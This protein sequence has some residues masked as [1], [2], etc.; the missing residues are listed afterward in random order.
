MSELANL[1]SAQLAKITK[2]IKDKEA[3]L[4]KRD[5]LQAK[6]D[7]ID[8]EL[9]KS[10]AAAPAK[11][12]GRKPGRKAAAPK[13]KGT[14]KRGAVKDKIV[15][16]LKANPKG[17]TVQDIASKIKLDSRNVHSWFQTTGKKLSG[18]T[19]VGRAMYT[20]KAAK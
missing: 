3:L 14:R 16:L 20:I 19:K 4:T 17:I 11:R 18:I 7:K 6:I 15:A 9:G 12:R 13:A 2:L 5:A 8:A 10:G 1:T